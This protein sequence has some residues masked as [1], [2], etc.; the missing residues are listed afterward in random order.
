M[1]NPPTL[2]EMIDSLVPSLPPVES[3]I[4]AS[5]LAEMQ[6]T[7]GS[8]ASETEITPPT[9][10]EMS[11]ILMET[12]DDVL[13]HFG[14]KGM[15][16]GVRRSSKQLASVRNGDGEEVGTLSGGRKI[17]EKLKQMKAGQVALL[18]T[19]DG[20]MITI[21]QKD[22][23]FR[24]VKL[25]ADQEGVLRTMRKDPTEMSTRELKEA[26]A[27]AKALD[28]YNKLFN[29]TP[30]A[31]QALKD[32]V[33]AMQLQQKY[34][35]A[36]AQ[37]NPSRTKRATDFIET[38]KPTAFS[39]WN[40]A[41]KVTNGA[42]S[43]NIANMIKSMSEPAPSAQSSSKG[44]RKTGKPRVIN[45]DIMNEAWAKSRGQREKASKKSDYVYDI[46]TMGKNDPMNPFVPELGLKK[47][48]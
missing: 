35:A 5:A 12:E 9:L 44:S 18:D 8:S 14:I 48:Q 7:L 43:D 46:T 42:L 27:R 47:T 34:G 45:V 13:E 38:V 29:P 24:E 25:S 23:T 33:E 20:P 3:T 32:K 40:M 36:Y 10:D 41:N 21:K 37:M 11:H 4:E 28:E 26:T 39:A 2:S 16:W 17:K 15:K 22:G 30:E 1:T 31:N 19:D 6:H